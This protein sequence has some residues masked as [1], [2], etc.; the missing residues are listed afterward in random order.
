MS[1]TIYIIP[2]KNIFKFGFKIT[3]DKKNQIGTITGRAWEMEKDLS[4]ATRCGSASI[5]TDSGFIKTKMQISVGGKSLTI[6][7]K[8]SLFSSKVDISG[9]PWAIKGNCEGYDYKIVEGRK[10]IASISHGGFWGDKIVVEIF[11]PTDELYV[12]AVVAALIAA[13]DAVQNGNAMI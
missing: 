1:G 6:V 11:N 8:P 5:R 13:K 2:S 7:R 12:T 9:L 10:K 3:D 4:V